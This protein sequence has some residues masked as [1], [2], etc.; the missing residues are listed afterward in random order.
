MTRLWAALLL[1]FGLAACIS[2]HDSVVA[3]INPMGWGKPAELSYANK[4]T[5]EAR[6][7]ALVLRYGNDARS[8]N[9]IIEAQSPS[10]A[11]TRDTLAVTLTI[12]RTSNNIHELNMPYRADIRLGEEGDY[13]FTI[14]PPA[15]TKGIW[16][17]GIDFKKQQ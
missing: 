12:E 2:G 1:P 15:E 3:D 4:D 13:I 17:V 10:G 5:I 8:G 11:K 9:Y 14:I 7:A 16:S 6:E